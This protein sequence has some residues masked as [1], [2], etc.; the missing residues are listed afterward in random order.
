MLAQGYLSNTYGIYGIIQYPFI[1]CDVCLHFV[2]RLFALGYIP[3]ST[4]SILS[5]E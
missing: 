2:T 3:Y 5:K 1:K 4:V